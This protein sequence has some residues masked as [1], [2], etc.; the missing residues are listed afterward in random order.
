MR[1]LRIHGRGGQGAVVASKVLS[2]AFFREGRWVQSF[3]AFGVER[4]GA[5]V[6]AFLRED[7][8]PIRVRCEIVAPDEVMVLDPTLLDGVD[9]TAGLAPGGLLLLNSP[10]PLAEKDDLGARYRVVTVDASGIAVRN[11]IGTPAH[12][13]VNTAILGAYAVASEAVTLDAVCAAIE[14]EVPLHAAANIRAAQE[15]A[16]AVREG[17]AGGAV[18]V[19]SSA[20]DQGRRRY[21]SD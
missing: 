18:G 17:Q 3:P 4:R 13:I 10:R 6:A 15:A 7:Q 12:P 8:H 19:P 5:P 2:V 1:E 9:V 16:E 11:G 21:G 20:A 14:E